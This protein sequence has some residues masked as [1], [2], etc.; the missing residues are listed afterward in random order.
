MFEERK[1]ALAFFCWF[2]WSAMAAIMMFPGDSAPGVAG[3]PVAIP[4]GVAAGPIAGPRR[5]ICIADGARATA[6][7]EPGGMYLS[8]SLLL[9]AGAASPT[10]TSFFNGMRP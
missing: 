7:S 10:A 1:L 9:G 8:G 6:Y 5:N 2:T 4:P 3:I